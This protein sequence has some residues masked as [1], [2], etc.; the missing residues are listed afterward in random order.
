MVKGQLVP[1]SAHHVKALEVFLR[2]FEESG[3]E[4]HGYFF[5]R[6]TN[7]KKVISTLEAWERGDE[8]VD[9][10]VPNSTWFWENDGVLQ[11]VINVRHHLTAWLEGNGGHIG[12]SVAPSQ[13]QQGVATSMLRSA[14]TKCKELE[15]PKAMLICDSDNAGSIKAIEA[16]NG[17]LEREE[18][19][20]RWYW[21]EL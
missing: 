19:G 20:Q 15:I 2:E 8:L 10:W 16:N 9:G 7:I 6:S 13:R 3:D 4:L 12:Y 14:L 11:G 5:N 18:N 21:I 17:V 1:L